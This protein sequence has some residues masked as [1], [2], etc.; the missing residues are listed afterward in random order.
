MFTK[1]LLLFWVA[2]QRPEATSLDILINIAA[3]G[4]SL[5]DH[6]MPLSF[7]SACVEHPPR[8]L[9]ECCRQLAELNLTAHLC[10]NSIH[11]PLKIRETEAQSCSALCPLVH[12]GGMRSKEQDCAV[13]NA[14][15]HPSPDPQVRLVQQHPA[16]VCQLCAPGAPLPTHRLC[17]QPNPGSSCAPASLRI[18]HGELSSPATAPCGAVAGSNPPAKSLSDRFPS[19]ASALRE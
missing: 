9:K 19:K 2:L 14:P 6:T 8:S 5:V 3:K 1:D 18:A 15:E 11:L 16:P 13:P 17:S 10:A 12:E 7:V 4:F